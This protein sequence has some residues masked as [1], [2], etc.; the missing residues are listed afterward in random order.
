MAVWFAI[1]DLVGTAD[2]APCAQAIALLH[3]V[4]RELSICGSVTTR[5]S[6]SLNK[7]SEDTLQALPTVTG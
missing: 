4:F 3:T 2:S 1:G 5:S 6:G 7:P